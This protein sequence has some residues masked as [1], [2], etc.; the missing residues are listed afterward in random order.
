MRM[1]TRN[2]TIALEGDG[3]PLY[4]DNSFLTTE[5]LHHATAFTSVEIDDTLLSPD[6]DGNYLLTLEPNQQLKLTYDVLTPPQTT[7]QSNNITSSIYL[8]LE[9]SS[10]S[11]ILYSAHNS[12]QLATLQI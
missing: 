1:P 8:E 6:A 4:S 10:G 11:G 12:Q 2:L 9:S 5:N 3:D 7:T